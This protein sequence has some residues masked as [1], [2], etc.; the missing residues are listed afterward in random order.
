MFLKSKLLRTVLENTNPL[1]KIGYKALDIVA[2]NNPTKNRPKGPDLTF[3]MGA[4]LINSLRDK[5]KPKVGSVVY[6][7]LAF[8]QVEHS[9]IYVGYNKIIHLDGSGKIEAVTPKQFLNRLDGTNLALHIYV[10]CKGTTPIGLK[11]CAERARAKL[12]EKLKYN[13][14]FNNCHKFSSYCLTGDINSD[15]TFFKLEETTHSKL[16]TD[17]WRIWDLPD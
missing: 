9:G 1:Y 3:G 7:G 5:V 6:C 4:G 11:R 2:P 15:T 14:F 13:L 10:P 8:N 16:G 17:N 12:G